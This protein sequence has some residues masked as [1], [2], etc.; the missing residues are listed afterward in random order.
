MV[1]L[2]PSGNKVV[3]LMEMGLH[4]RRDLIGV[5]LRGTRMV[6][7]MM[8]GLLRRLLGTGLG[9]L[10]RPFVVKLYHFGTNC[11]FNKHITII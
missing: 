4:W 2:V 7:V 3:Y 1:S 10:K 5:G 11:I 9:R 8:V 6:G